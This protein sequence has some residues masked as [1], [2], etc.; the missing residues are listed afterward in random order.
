[1]QYTSHTYWYAINVKPRHE[2][3]VSKALR[4]KGYEEFLPLCL[5]LNKI[6]KPGRG[7]EI[8]LF[9]GYVFCRFNG[10][11]RLPILTTPGVFSILGN[12]SNLLPV[13]EDEIEMIQRV[14]QA[15]MNPQPWPY[16]ERGDV[17]RVEHGPLRGVEGIMQESKGQHRLVVS[18]KLL[19]RAVSVLVDRS[20]IAP[21]SVEYERRAARVLA[22]G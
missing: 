19:Q 8:P 10:K 4:N 3:A 13:E 12:G 18:V 22:C 17:V 7:A 21:A 14:V 11:D 6:A 1:M 20:D 16:L 15:R 2:K 9:P 5:T